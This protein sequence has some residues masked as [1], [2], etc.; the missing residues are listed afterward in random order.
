MACFE[1]ACSGLCS[2]RACWSPGER[3]LSRETGEKG[4]ER[5]SVPSIEQEP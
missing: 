3:V 1:E 4:G 2:W 5:L